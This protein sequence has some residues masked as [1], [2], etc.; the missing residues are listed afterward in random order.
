MGFEKLLHTPGN[1]DDHPYGA[2]HMLRKYLRPPGSPLGLPG[3]SAQAGA[4]A[5]AELSAPQ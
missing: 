2:G 5:K 1:L 3:G 4:E